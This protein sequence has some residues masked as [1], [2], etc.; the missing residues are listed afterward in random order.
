[1]P[2]KIATSPIS[3]AARKIG[4]PFLMAVCFFL[5]A[6]S[7][8]LTFFKDWRWILTGGLLQLAMLFGFIGLLFLRFWVKI[9]I[10]ALMLAV[11]WLA[12]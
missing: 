6:I 4:V 2:T 1:M 8:L 5:L 3:T 9:T 12:R 10:L 7:I 11:A